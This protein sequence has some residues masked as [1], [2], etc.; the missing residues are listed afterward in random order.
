MTN[1]G[2]VNLTNVLVTDSLTSLSQTIPRLAPG[3]TQ[4]FNPTYTVTQSDV[5]APIRNTATA[6]GTDPCG[7]PIGPVT[8]LFS[9]DS[10]YNADL[11]IVKTANIT[12]ATVGTVIGYT[13]NVSN[14]GNVN[15]TNV[16]VT[17]VKLGLSWTIPN[18]TPGASQTFNP[19][20]TV[21]QSDICA[22]INNTATANGTDPCGG[23][24]GPEN[25]SVSVPTTFS[26][27]LAITKTANVSFATVGTVIGYTINVSNTGNVNLTNVLVTD[28]KLGLLQTIPN[29]IPGAS[30]TFNPTYTVTQA[31]ICAP[32]NN[33]VTANGTDPCGG[34]VGPESASVSVPTTFSPALAITKTAN[35]SSA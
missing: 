16:L 24:V 35:V 10:V 31:D 11:S 13:I 19:T 32:I 15:L 2:N 8:A 6:N 27:A 28:V 18:L 7:K 26:P 12:T 17:D 20:Y 9:V 1:T 23:A 22:P 29:L 3:A 21:T 5:C 14:T 34:A 33:T 25:A 30:Q 4:T